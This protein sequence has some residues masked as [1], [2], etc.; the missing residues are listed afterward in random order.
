MKNKFSSAFLLT[1]ILCLASLAVFAGAPPPP[2]A[3][4]IDG[5]L[6]FLVVACAGYGAKKIYDKKK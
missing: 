4:P 3:L 5:G 2:N 6:S 1:G